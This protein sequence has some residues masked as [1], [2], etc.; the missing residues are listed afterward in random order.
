M[1][2]VQ[3]Y[4][5][6]N[7]EEAL[8]QGVMWSYGYASD[9]VFQKFIA[10]QIPGT[11]RQY[12]LELFFFFNYLP[13]AKVGHKGFPTD[14]PREEHWWRA[15]ERRWP[16]KLD[17][18][19]RLQGE[20]CKDDWSEQIIRAIAEYGTI[21]LLGGSG[22]GKTKTPIAFAITAFDYF[23]FAKRGARC[24]FS[25][26]SEK[27]IKHATWHMCNRLYVDSNKECSENISHGTVLSGSMQ[28]QRKWRGA[29]EQAIMQGVLITNDSR[30]ETRI[31]SLTGAHDVDCQILITDEAQSSPEALS[32]AGANL[33]TKAKWAW[34][35][36]AGN[37]AA[38]DDYL[39][40]AA[41]PDDGWD[42]VDPMKHEE[43]AL[44]W[45]N[46][47][48]GKE[49][50]SI[51]FDNDFSPG[52]EDPI[53]YHYRPTRDFWE[54]E[55]TSQKRQTADYYRFWKGWFAPGFVDEAVIRYA[56]IE[57]MNCHAFPKIDRKK[58]V[59]NFMTFDSAPTSTDRAPLGHMQ[60]IHEGN[61]RLLNVA[62]IFLFPKLNPDTYDRD[63]ANI[64]LDK[65][66]EWQVP[67]GNLIMD[68]TN[69][70]GPL[71]LLRE[72]GF[73]CYGMQ[74]HAMASD[75]PIDPI[76][77][78]P[79]KHLYSNCATEAAF[80]LEALIRYGQVRGLNDAVIGGNGVEEELCTRR[81]Q[82]AKQSGKVALE[83]KRNS[84][85]VGGF[86]DRK[87]FSPDIFDILCQA[88]LFARDHLN[89]WPG[90]VDKAPQIKQNKSSATMRG[91]WNRRFR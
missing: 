79:A 54:T 10:E 21:N 68:H 6:A 22:Q 31:D 80:L 16:S 83:Q 36:R 70:S 50:I 20:M 25:S 72:K 11:P 42:M 91:G 82:T 24:Q 30:A 46:H 56:V 27:K 4:S 37:P 60:L 1:G 17:D 52:M 65:A 38:S 9:L 75:K 23:Y 55:W 69:Y 57:Q 67:S 88:A 34:E 51:R 19:G 14:V 2:R 47:K 41:K 87:G 33:R 77:G 28:I 81:T 3:Q 84:N 59:V 43:V 7:R 45:V 76:V 90:E 62:Q 64:I 5:F 86:R 13:N 32:R 39:G 66:V 73:N 58:E 63:A 40:N 12:D 15:A 89:F 85:G 71:S 49:A 8:A 61:R 53:R 44:S 26:V 29:G 35:I 48:D 78:T 74:Y 18:Q